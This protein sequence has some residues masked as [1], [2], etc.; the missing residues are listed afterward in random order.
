MLS[1][2]SKTVNVKSAIP[3]IPKSCYG[4]VMILEF[5]LAGRRHAMCRRKNSDA[6]LR[7]GTRGGPFKHPRV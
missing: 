1:L 7:S 5:E 4:D 2:A 3:H 6:S